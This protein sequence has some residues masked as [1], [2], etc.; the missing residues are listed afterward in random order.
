MNRPVIEEARAYPGQAIAEQHQGIGNIDRHEFGRGI[1]RCQ[2]CESEC[3]HDMRGSPPY[4]GA[5]ATA[6]QPGE[7]QEGAKKRRN[8]HGHHGNG[9]QIETH[10]ALT[11]G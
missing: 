8:E 1:A 6:L 3:I 5:N 10:A 9:L 11:N 7:Y 4:R 2:Q